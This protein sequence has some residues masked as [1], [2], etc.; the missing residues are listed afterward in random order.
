MRTSNRRIALDIDGVLADFTS[1]IIEFARQAGIPGMPERPEQVGDW[2]WSKWRGFGR[3]WRLVKDDPEFWLS[4]NTITRA[5]EIPFDPVAYITHRPVPDA[6]TLEWLEEHGYPDVP[7]Y[8]VDGSKVPAMRAVGAT[9]LVDD[10]PENF[11]DVNNEPDLTCFLFDRHHNRHFR[12]HGMR[13]KRLA[14]VNDFVL[15]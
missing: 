6:V 13:V 9:V 7:L 14:D 2:G 12:D 15:M 10:K 8:T 11:T 5:H 1:G 4:L 3:T